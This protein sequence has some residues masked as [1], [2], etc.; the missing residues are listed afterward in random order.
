MYDFDI[1]SQ[2]KK[3]LNHSKKLFNCL[4]KAET[5]H[6]SCSDG[7]TLWCLIWKSSDQHIKSLKLENAL[8][9][10]PIGIPIF[11]TPQSY[12]I[13]EL[14][15]SWGGTHNTSICKAN[16]QIIIMFKFKGLT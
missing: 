12:I 2:Y 13:T 5:M 14:V 3:Y 8:L 7:I 1:L 9:L 4:E 11:F 10:R 16:R 6:A 15:F